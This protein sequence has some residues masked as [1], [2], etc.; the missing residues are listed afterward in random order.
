MKHILLSLTLL[1]SI[2]Q[3]EIRTVKAEGSKAAALYRELA[4]FMQP[5]CDNGQCTTKIDSSSCSHTHVMVDV[6]YCMIGRW[7]NDRMIIHQ[8]QNRAAEHFMNVL[9]HI[10]PLRCAGTED[11]WACAVS[12]NTATCVQ[13]GPWY[14]RITNCTIKVEERPKD[15]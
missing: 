9:G 8:L 5:I 15:K 13:K 11:S 2:A 12:T 1:A 4:Q 10:V 14:N 6:K 7:V 3:A